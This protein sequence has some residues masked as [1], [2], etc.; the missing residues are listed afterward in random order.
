MILR[1][2]RGLKNNRIFIISIVIFLITIF[3]IVE[4]SIKINERKKEN[5]EISDSKPIITLNGEE[6]VIIEVGGNYIEQG[7]FATDSSDGI[8]TNSVIKTNNIDTEK[9]GEYEVVYQVTNSRGIMTTKKRNV[10]VVPENIKLYPAIN[11]IPE[12]K[13]KDNVQINLKIIGEKYSH[14]KLPDGTTSNEKNIKYVVNKN[15]I[16][17]FTIYDEN[18]QIIEK[19]II[20]NNIDN[21]PPT[22]ECII[23]LENDEVIYNVIAND[24]SGIKGYSYYD[25]INYTE[26]TDKNTFKTKMDY[27]QSEVLIEDVAGNITKLICSLIK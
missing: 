18:N 23:K 7:V 21:I 25:G 9:I 11:I 24:D 19:K 12:N 27:N 16:Y 4:S 1:I 3:L 26:Y 22:G 15:D 13:T 2:K 8:L 14:I 5:L 10:Y 17:L 20:I 6:D